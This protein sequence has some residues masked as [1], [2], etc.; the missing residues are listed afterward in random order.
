M[1]NYSILVLILMLSGCEKGDLVVDENTIWKPDPIALIG[2]SQVHLSW[3]NNSI[4]HPVGRKYDIIDPDQFEIF[5]SKSSYPKFTKLKKLQ[6][7]KT[8][9]YTLEGLENDQPVYFY[10]TSIKKASRN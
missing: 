5:I 7:D 4:F 2:D 10:I 9:A 3:L 8:Y 1:K 6:N